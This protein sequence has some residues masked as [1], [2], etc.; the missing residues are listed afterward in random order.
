M[1]KKPPTLV[2]PDAWQQTTWKWSKIDSLGKWNWLL[3]EHP[4]F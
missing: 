2:F 3:A 4:L 1:E